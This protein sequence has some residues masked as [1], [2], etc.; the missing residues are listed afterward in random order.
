MASAPGDAVPWLEQHLQP[1]R[2]LDPDRLAEWITQLDSQQFETRDA[3]RRELE[4]AGRLAERA[5]RRALAGAPSAE[6][7][8]QAE[9]LLDKLKWPIRDAEELRALRGVEALEHAG[10][11]QARRAVERMAGGAP[12][13]ILTQEAVKAARRVVKLRDSF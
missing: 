5:L 12:E 3:A 9:M 6:V 11:P 2:P 10:T 8:R 7:R 1:V 13:A 4:T